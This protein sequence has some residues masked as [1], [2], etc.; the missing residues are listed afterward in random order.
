MGSS[1]WVWVS[2]EPSYRKLP[3]GRLEK[4][5]ELGRGLGF[6]LTG[7]DLESGVSRRVVVHSL[8]KSVLEQRQLMFCTI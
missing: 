7:E 6:C 2:V 1:G 8:L 4:P 3:A 5:R